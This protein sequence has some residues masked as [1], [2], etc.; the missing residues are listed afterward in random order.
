M[1][2]VHICWTEPH[3]VISS[4]WDGERYC[5]V[6][7]KRREF[8]RVV[9]APV[10]LSYYGPHSEIVCAFCNAVD[11]DCFPGSEREWA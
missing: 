10:G 8:F 1:S 11:G 4:D 5:F 9:K 3:Q 7:R 2:N 6:C